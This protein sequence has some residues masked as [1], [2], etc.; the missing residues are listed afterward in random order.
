MTEASKEA[1]R[2][3]LEY[4]EVKSWYDGVGTELK[5]STRN[6][7]LVYLL[8]YFGK[9]NPAYFL[10]TAQ[11]NP[12][13][14]AIAIKS[15][16][17]ELYKHSMN[18]A[19]QTKY[20]LQSFLDFHEVDL[21]VKAKIKV[22]R[23]RKKTELTWEDADR[24]IAETDE[25]YRSLFKFMKWSGLGED[26]V[27]EIQKSPSIQRS[28]D[29]QRPNTNPYIK[30]DLSPRKSTL[31]EFFTLAPKQYMPNFPLK[32]KTYKDRGAALIE[33]HDMQNVWRRAAKK[34]KLWQEG[35]GPHTLRSTFRSQCARSGVAKAVAEFCMGHGG[36]DQYGY[37]R[38]VQDEQYVASELAKL[39]APSGSPEEVVMKVQVD[40]FK[41]Q[42]EAKHGHPLPPEKERVLQDIMKQTQ[43]ADRLKRLAVFTAREDETV[44]RSQPKKHRT[45]RGTTAHNGG[46]MVETPYET[47][48]VGEE[49]LVPLLNAGWEIVKELS[50]GRI[51]VRRPK[52]L[53]E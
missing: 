18:A 39:W 53:D 7:Y 9:E 42:Y 5:E 29:V 38:E 31:D 46:T 27:M 24:I 50:G 48:I 47:C 32:T 51:I 15:K 20:A 19:H 11:E 1:L 10:K 34:V 45:A 43:T 23:I 35:L 33:P 49:D 25:P 2:K 44:A 8:R 37:S 12:R 6:L 22:R 17:G 30:I 41:A 13:Q 21:E 3:F 28:I 52:G 14:V 4:P 40:M 36:G 16:L 26:E